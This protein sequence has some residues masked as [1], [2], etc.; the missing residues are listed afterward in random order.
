MTARPIQSLRRPSG[1]NEHLAPGEHAVT[2]DCSIVSLEFGGHR[3]T[4]ESRRSVRTK[5]AELSQSARGIPRH[6]ASTTVRRGSGR[7]VTRFP[8][9]GAWRERATT[10]RRRADLTHEAHHAE[11]HPQRAR[12]DQCTNERFAWRIAHHGQQ[13]RGRGDD[14]RDRAG[15]HPPVHPVQHLRPHH[16]S[17][18]VPRSAND[19]AL[20]AESSCELVA[21]PTPP[22]RSH[23]ANDP[24]RE[25]ARQPQP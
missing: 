11:R 8:L 6:R 15:A 1:K 19:R 24:R 17:D 2:G 22:Q 16:R 9:S 10:G 14:R 20:S 5:S 12:H 7:G 3:R 18:Q 4:T 21:T 25:P 23:N 13:P